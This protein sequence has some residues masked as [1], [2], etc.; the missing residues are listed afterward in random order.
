MTAVKGRKRL[1]IM[2]HLSVAVIF[3]Q[4]PFQ[5]P[6]LV[7]LIKLRE[8]LSHEQQLL[9]RMNHHKTICRAQIGKLLIILAGHLVDHGALAVHD[10]IMRQNKDIILTVHIREAECQAILN[11]SPEIRIRLHI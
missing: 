9:T 3:K 6:V 5:L 2:L 8:I 11:T 4:I 1:Y 7:P 10:L